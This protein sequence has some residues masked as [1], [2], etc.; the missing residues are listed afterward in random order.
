MEMALIDINKTPPVLD[1][2]DIIG[3]RFYSSEALETVH[4]KFQPKGHLKAHV[5]PVDVVFL[6]L[7]GKGE[8]MIGKDHI[9]AAKLQAIMSPKDVPHA[10]TNIGEE[11]LEVLVLK[12]PRPGTKK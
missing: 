8:F 4:L 7:E 2:G 6:V 5:T 9:V 11:A 1:T 12:A 10:I 3:K